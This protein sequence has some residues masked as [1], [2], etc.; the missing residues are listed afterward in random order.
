MPVL[1]ELYIREL[2]HSYHGNRAPLGLFL[3]G[4]RLVGY[5]EV[6][7]QYQ[8]FLRYALSLPDVWVV[9]ISEVGDEGIGDGPGCSKHS[10]IY[11]PKTP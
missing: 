2:E 7:L 1:A 6:G 4:A 11:L 5:P 10:L 9:T 8:A 3:H